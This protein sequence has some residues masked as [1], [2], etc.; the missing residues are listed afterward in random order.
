MADLTSARNHIQVA[1]DS[2]AESLRQLNLGIHGHPETAHEEV[3]AH[4]TLTSFLETRGFNVTRHAYG[5]STAFEA[6]LG[7]SGP[8]VIFCAEYDALP[9]IGRACGHNLIA[10]SSMAAFLGLA[11]SV[12]QLEVPGR[13]RILG[14][15]AEE[16]HGGKIQLIDAGAFHDPAIVAAIMVHPTAQRSI[17]EGY[18][19][20]AGWE[21]IANALIQ[22]EF[23]GKGA[24]AGGDPW[25]GVSALDA[26]VSAY[27]SLAMLRQ[28]I[29]PDERIHRIIEDGGK[30][31]RGRTAAR[32]DELL[33]RAKACFEA[34][35]VSTGCSVSYTMEPM[36]KDIV[37]NDPFCQIYTE[38]IAALG[39]KVQLKSDGPTTVSTDMGNVSYAV[40]SFHG[41]FGIPTPDGVPPHHAGFAKAAG[42]EEAHHEAIICGKAMAMLGWRL[43]TRS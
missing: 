10:T 11:N 43:L 14:T 37:V 17:P 25:N 18:Q 15:P 34:A 9:G 4:D 38:E 7:T 8:I 36:Y 35:G 29:R 27:N 16:A 21:S 5:L 22:V 2:N 30:S 41:V 20:V 1:T 6:E 39:R 19:G 28:H 42:L 32:T 24:H 13:V 23:H 31:I 12:K 3:H 40:P 33:A 26:A